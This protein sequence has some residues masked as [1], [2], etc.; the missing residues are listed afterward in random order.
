[1]KKII[2][3]LLIS[4]SSFTIISCGEE[5][6]KIPISGGDVVKKVLPKRM[7]A[8]VDRVTAA[9]SYAD[10][11]KNKILAE[12]KQGIGEIFSGDSNDQYQCTSMTT[13]HKAIFGKQAKQTND[14]GYIVASIGKLTKL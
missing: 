14:C 3:A 12:A 7:H 2:Y 13:F 4:Y 6:P 10:E 9:A 11:Q 1:M 8:N 5:L